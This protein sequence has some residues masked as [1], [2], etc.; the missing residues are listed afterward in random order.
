MFSC[1]LHT[2]TNRSDGHLTPMESIDRA[3]ALGL[4]VMAITDHDMIL[5]LFGE[6]DGKRVNLEAYAA[7]KGVEL[8]RGIEVSCDTNNDD[9]HIIGLFC[10]WDAPEF[11]ALE[12][13]VQESR[14]GSY[15]KMVK[16]MALAGYRIS[17]EEVL[18]AAG[19]TQ[20]P[21]NIQKKQIFEFLAMKGYVESWQDG[22]RLVQARPEF[23]TGREKPD[24]VETIGLIHKTGGIAVMAHPF[25]VK[26][27]PIY[28]GRAMSRFAYMDMLLDA[29]LDGIETSYTYDKTSY[30]GTL[31]KEEIAEQ[32]YG[33][34]RD[35]GIFFSGGSDFHGDFVKKAANP[36][37][38]GECGVSYGYYC[39]NIR[40]RKFP[41]KKSSK[42]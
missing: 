27:N 37:E 35:T 26:E 11:A 19:K 17:W 32:I 18:E 41:V 16:R 22:K 23:Q 33:R 34:Y 31:S 40:S 38:L 30:T 42:K 12:R 9:V 8:L 36:R 21:E 5:P 13:R 10:D 28:Q 20:C 15:Q 39:E 6:K 7:A 29:G 2:H 24:P 25:L 3:A 4:K 14:T 1:D